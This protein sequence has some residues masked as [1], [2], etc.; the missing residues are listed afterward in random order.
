MTM[1]D[2]FKQLTEEQRLTKCVVAIITKAPALSGVMMIGDRVI[3][4]DPSVPTACTNG[5]DE[6]YGRAFVASLNDAELRFLILHEVYHKLFRHLLTWYHLYQDDHELANMA[7]DYVINLMIQAEYGADGWVKMPEGGCYDT[8]YTGWNTPQV[9]KDLQDNKPQDED[10]QGT[11]PTRGFDQHDWEGAQGMDSEEVRDLAREIDEAVR[12][13][14]LVA[15]KTGSAGDR[16][17]EELLQPQANWRE[18]LREFVQNTCAGN[19]FSTWRRPNR[20]YMGADIYMPSGVSE[21]VACIAEHNDMSGSIGKREQQIM[22]SELVGI[23]EAVKPDELHVSYWDTEVCGYEKYAG[24]ELDTVASKT[25]PVGG[26]GTDVRCVPQYLRENGI[27]PQASIVFTDGYIYGGWGAWD[28]PVLW[29]IV[30]N[31][32]AKP[33]HGVVVHVK[34][35]DL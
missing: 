19:D 4:D 23:C 1:L 34:S 11:S 16:N 28:H 6:W 31:K 32:N 3:S 35:G 10:G 20:R 9:F 8:K 2:M 21:K 27:K 15:G 33:D 30:D 25:K 13:G 24:D 17:L 5:R 29:V 22:I 14:A 12:Q 26:G 7:C 18:V